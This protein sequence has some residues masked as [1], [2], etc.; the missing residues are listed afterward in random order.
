MKF[1]KITP[2][3]NFKVGIKGDI[4][5]THSMDIF[6]EDDEQVTFKKKIGKNITEFDVCKKNWGYYALPSINSRLKDF[7]FSTFIISNANKRIYIWIVHNSKKKEFLQY[8]KNEKQIILAN[9]DSKNFKKYI[10]KKINKN[11]YFCNEGCNYKSL[12][13]IKKKPRGETKII[14]VKKYFR[15]ILQ[16]INCKHYINESFFSKDKRFYHGQYV[17]KTY[18]DINEIKKIFNKIRKLNEKKSDN[19][20]R[21]K[22]IINIVNKLDIKKEINL[23]DIGTGLGV[24]LYEIKKR[25]NWHCEGLDPD[26]YQSL[27]MNM[28]LKIKNYESTLEKFKVRKKYNFITLNKVLEHQINPL[29]F[30][31]IIK[32]HMDKKSLL[33]IEVPDGEISHKKGS[34]INNEEFY[35]EHHH[36]FS[37]KSLFLLIENCNLNILNINRIKEPSGKNTIYAFCQNNF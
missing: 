37:V 5:I 4:T 7:N 11:N 2:N 28:N 25:T 26:K 13:T 29:G 34:L 16:C 12:I 19:I 24:F 1:K 10:F 30:L 18:G 33:Y 17:E 3:R 31:K 14:E 36:I 21:V 20:N 23:L 35:I 27:H 9:V 6:L 22:R 32:K 15:R 8:V